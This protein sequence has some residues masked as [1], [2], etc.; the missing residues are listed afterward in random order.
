MNKINT[1]THLT[2]QKRELATHVVAML[3]LYK[4]SY[5]IQ[6]IAVLQQSKS[7]SKQHAKEAVTHLEAAWAEH[8]KAFEL[9]NP[10][11]VWIRTEQYGNLCVTYSMEH[12]GIHVEGLEPDEDGEVDD[13]F[14]KEW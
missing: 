14:D 13:W 7:K 4:M 6:M 1:L 12:Q 11:K 5:H 9:L 10:Q 8:F 2:A 3:N